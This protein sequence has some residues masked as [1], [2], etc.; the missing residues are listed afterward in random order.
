[1]YSPGAEAVLSHPL[2]LQLTGVLQLDRTGDEAHLAALLHQTPDPPVVVVL[3][4]VRG[5]AG[6]RT[7]HLRAPSPVF[8]PSY[9]FDVQEVFGFKGN[10]HALHR[11]VVAGAGVV[12]DIRPHGE[13]HWFGLQQRQVRS[14]KPAG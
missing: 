9:L 1:M 2:L 5:R 3:L 6:S 7:A 10:G 11:D 4:R 8:T 13:C 14:E 12:A